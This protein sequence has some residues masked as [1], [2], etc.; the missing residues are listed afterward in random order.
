MTSHVPMKI[1]KLS[2]RHLS[3]MGTQCISPIAVNNINQDRLCLNLHKERNLRI[4]ITNV[5][6]H[7]E[8]RLSRQRVANNFEILSL[9]RKLFGE[10]KHKLEKNKGL[11][12]ELFLRGPVQVFLRSYTWLVRFRSKRL[13]NWGENS[14]RRKNTVAFLSPNSRFALQNCRRQ[15]L[16]FPLSPTYSMFQK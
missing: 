14:I 8:G 6:C 1:Q 4:K 12:A 3:K 16:L 13:P 11:R 2:Y 15:Y 9:T 10:N 7:I 5:R